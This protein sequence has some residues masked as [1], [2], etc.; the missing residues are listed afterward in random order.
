MCAETIPMNRDS[1]GEAV[2]PGGEKGGGLTNRGISVFREVE[3]V[4]KKENETRSAVA[5]AMAGQVRLWRNTDDTDD[6]AQGRREWTREIWCS[7]Y[8]SRVPGY[9]E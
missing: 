9:S 2:S 8:A 5:K 7:R 1:S 6:I 3:P 4:S